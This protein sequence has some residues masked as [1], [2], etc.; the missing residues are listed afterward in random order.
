M[1]V[2]AVDGKAPP[3]PEAPLPANVGDREALWTFSA[4]VLGA[5]G[6]KDTSFNGFARLKV[7]PGAVNGVTGDTAQGR[8]IRFVDGHAEGI[9]RVTAVF[10]PSRLWLEDLGYVPALPGQTAGCANG[11]D[12]DGDVA[13]DYPNDPGCAFADDMS[14]EAGKYLTGVSQALAYARPTIGDVQGH[15]SQ[16]PYPAVAVDIKTDGVNY[17]VVTRVASAGFFVTDLGDSGGYN[18]MFAFNFNTPEGMRVCDR[19]SHLSGTAAEFFGFT[20]INFPSYNVVEIADDDCIVPEPT[21]LT[22]EIIGSPEQMEKLESGLVRLTGFS[23]ATK[24]GAEPAVNNVFTETATNCDLNGDGAI[25]YLNDA[26]SSCSNACSADPDCSEWT[27]FASRG[28]Y[29]A[30]KGAVM[31]QVNTG[32]AAGFDPRAYKD[33]NG[34]KLVTALSGTLRNFSGGSLNWTVETRCRDDLVCDDEEACSSALVPSKTACV[35]PRTEFDNDSG[36]N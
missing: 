3:S 10:G 7:V 33:N 29:K 20:E 5:D 6:Q 15:G 4:D 28:N 24:L 8:N 34:G 14:E 1:T 26:E 35:T 13:V 12:D 11:I 36:T 9:A 30:H 31:I 18:H 27:G 23:I 22:D 21:E 32:T 25:D 2:T 19:L 16:T 17:V